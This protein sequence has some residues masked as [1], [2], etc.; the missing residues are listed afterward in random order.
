MLHILRYFLKGLEGMEAATRWML[1]HPKKIILAFCLVTAFFALEMK[2]LAIDPSVDIFVPRDHPEVVFFREMRDVFGLFNYFIVG[3]VDQRD[4]GVYLPGTLQLVKDLSLAFQ[5]IPGVTDVLSLYEFPYI[6]GD[7]EGMTVRPLYTDVSSDPAW[8][9][10]LEEKVRQWP[11]LLGNIVSRDGRATALLVRYAR[12]STPE[13]RR[14]V[15]HHAMD[16][17]RAAEA[18]HQEMF[19]AGM[20]AIETCISDSIIRDLRRLLPGVYAVVILCL[21][22]SFRRRLGVVLPLLTVMISTVWAMGLMALLGV[23]LNTLTSSLPILL[24][25]V[26]TAYTI[27]ILFYFLHR[28]ALTADREEALVQAVSQ[29]GYAVVMA[30]L[31]TVGGFA[32]LI[33][34][35]VVPI[36]QLGLFAA[37]GT[38]VALMTSV[39]FIPAILKLSMNRLH[40]PTAASDEPR[41]GRRLDRFLRWY[42]RSMIRYRR[43]VYAVCLLLT[44]GFLA[45]ALRI[46]PES[47]YITQ[48]KKS[49]YIYKSDQMINQH[50]NGSS[51][52]NIIVDTGEPDGLKDPDV[53]KRVESLQR[54]VEGLPHVGGAIS[55]ADYIKR[56]NQA[57]HADE[58]EYL[59]IPDTR[60]MV[61][62]CLLLYSLSGDESDLEEAINDDYSMGCITVSLRSGSTRYAAGM[63]REIEEYNEEHT[64]LQ[65]GMTAAMVLGK[66]TDDLTIKGQIESIIASTIVVFSLVALILRSFVGGIFAILPLV[67]CIIINFGILGWGGIPLQTGTA[68]VASIA[69]GIGIDYAIHFLNMSR[70]QA[71]EEQGIETAQEA[72]GATAGRAIVYNAA[73]VGLGFLVMA[74]SS[75]IGVIQFGMFITLTMLTAST[76]TLTLLPCLIYSFRPRFLEE[77]VKGFY[78]NGPTGK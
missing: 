62:Q 19:V 39:T 68:I 64:Q 7:E 21:W 11:L 17:I 73:A 43:P 29:V 63:I 27:H 65:I 20:S 48:F 44:I 22:L 31:T 72:T 38:W 57:L 56:M 13:L 45:G 8:L 28:V 37:F 1:R 4:K 53:L 2:N 55:I 42:V 26:G 60:E 47:D 34:A 6:E 49:S 76:A 15:Y 18:P 77:Q 10:S 78:S 67:L 25:A 3:V 52:L 46:Y 59:R 30:G 61:A 35:G 70:I 16:T 51:V 54:Y 32:A 14:S 75:F 74:F 24:T 23:T 41:G 40:L 5:D 58:Q 12:D 36:R 66:V 33:V 69:L 50:F 9:S 71:R